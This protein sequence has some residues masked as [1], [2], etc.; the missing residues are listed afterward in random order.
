MAKQMHKILKVGFDLD[1]VLL[2]NP[3]RIARPII[4]FLKKLII[5]KEK[6]KFH[7]PKTG[8]QKFIWL[9]LHKTSFI[10]APGYSE[11][12]N[13]VI[14]KKI[15][16]YIISARYEALKTDFNYWLNKLDAKK[17]F[18]SCHYNNN[19]EQ[20]HLFKEKTIKQLDLD[21][22]VEDNWDIVNH[23]AKKSKT[24]V[25]WIYNLLDRKIKYPYKYPSLNKA[26]LNIKKILSTV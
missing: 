5:P 2:Y 11:I 7:L 3:A 10:V 24:K 12:K 9:L 6:N 18:S 19:D 26:V 15:K 1:G 20:P 16:V 4:V 22:F 8:L 23:L 14:Q 21:I 25:F 17:Y 13:L